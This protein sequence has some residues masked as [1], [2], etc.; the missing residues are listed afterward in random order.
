M[1][2]GSTFHPFSHHGW[3]EDESMNRQG[4]DVMASVMSSAA[5]WYLFSVGTSSKTVCSGGLF[6]LTHPL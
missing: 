5:V 1:V 2:Q 4:F 6:G 3:W